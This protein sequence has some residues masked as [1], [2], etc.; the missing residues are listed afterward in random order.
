MDYYTLYVRRYS[1]QN[2]YKGKNIKYIIQKGIKKIGNK[3]ISNLSERS[4]KELGFAIVCALV[5]GFILGVFVG[6]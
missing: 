4:R 3:E 6:F 5:L 1:I 2:I